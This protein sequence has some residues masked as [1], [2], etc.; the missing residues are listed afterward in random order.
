MKE[1]NATTTIGDKEIMD[2]I[3]LDGSN[4]EGEFPYW[5]DIY[6]PIPNVSPTATGPT[7]ME[8]DSI[9]THYG[10]ET[11]GEDLE[12]VREHNN[13]N[14]GTVWTVMDS[15]IDD[16]IVLVSG[17]RLVNRISYMVTEEP[18]REEHRD[19]SF[20]MWHSDEEDEA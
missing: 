2:E 17:M 20:T 13:E 1:V 9:E 6:K 14:P 16:D 3:F 12:A 15:D 8:D 11:Y 18:V 7:L 19:I 5:A 10:F 4:W